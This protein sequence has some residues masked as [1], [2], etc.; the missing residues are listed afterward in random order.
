VL[1]KLGYLVG[2]NDVYIFDV[3][4]LKLPHH[5]LAGRSSLLDGRRRRYQAARAFYGNLD[6]DIMLVGNFF[7]AK[8]AFCHISAQLPVLTNQLINNLLT[9]I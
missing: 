8:T 7:V 2:L 1:V 6:V 9:N 3:N 5:T 4:I